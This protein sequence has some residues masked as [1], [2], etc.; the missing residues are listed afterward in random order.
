M[1][2][3]PIVRYAPPY[4]TAARLAEVTPVAVQRDGQELLALPLP[5][6]DRAGN[7]IVV[8]PEALVVAR[9]FDG[10]RDLRAVQR[11]LHESTGQLVHVERIHG[12]AMALFRA[13]LLTKGTP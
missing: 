2:D 11:A 12:L 6:P 4:G 7:A 10:S 8:S 13:G 5:G 9:L 3:V 1:T